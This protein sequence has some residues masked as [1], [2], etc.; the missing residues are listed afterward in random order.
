MI[1]EPD[2]DTKLSW[3]YGGER[4]G[5]SWEVACRYAAGFLPVMTVHDAEVA[6]FSSEMRTRWRR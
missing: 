2:P 6:T 3:P 1:T 5:Y 4:I